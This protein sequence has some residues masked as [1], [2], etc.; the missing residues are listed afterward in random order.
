MIVAAGILILAPDPRTGADTALML[1]RGGGSDH[2]WEWAFPGGHV[3]AGESLAE[4]AARECEE[5]CGLGV[6]PELLKESWTRG[7]AKAEFAAPLDGD[8]PGTPVTPSEDVDFTTFLHRIKSQF[9]PVLCDEHVAWCWAPV[10]RPPGPVHPGAAVALGRLRWNELDVARAI[11]DGRLMSPVHYENVWLFALRI[12]GTGV[13]YRSGLKEYVWREPAEWLNDEFL[14]RC[15]GLQ[16]IWVH[17]KGATLD[18]TEFAQRSIGAIFLPYLKDQDVWGVA[19]VYD[20]EAAREMRDQQVSTSPTVV[21]GPE[22]GNER[23]TMEDGKRILVEGRPRLLDHVAICAA[24][25]WDK[26]GAPVGVD[27]A[28]VVE[29]VADAE[30]TAEQ[31]FS[32]SQRLLKERAKA[33]EAGDK[34]RAADLMARSKDHAEHAMHMKNAARRGA[35]PVGFD[36]YKHRMDAEWSEGN[37]PRGP[38]GQFFHGTSSANAKAIRKEG[39]DPAKSPFKVNY[40]TESR[41][42]ASKYSK[43]S[44]KSGQLGS[45]LKINPKGLNPKLLKKDP[46]AGIWQYH[47]HIGPEH[48]SED[49]AQAP[50]GGSASTLD[51]LT[52]MVAADS[53]NLRGRL[54]ALR[55]RTLR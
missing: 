7:V 19:K 38:D 12:T 39:M 14:A 54:L 41:G 1:L 28:G 5:E 46:T 16:V 11:A 35:K 18:S 22:S 36:E 9:E 25:V 15:N 24:G 55:A 29:P 21:F 43:L 44:S 52:G 53:N 37:H 2:P 6:H 31:H 49:A 4:A 30:M 20:D 26:G 3:E 17:P 47:G 10:E 48:I 27:R 40:L 51:A 34:G 13:A 42:E 33:L 50:A 32:E 8:P 45:V 23:L